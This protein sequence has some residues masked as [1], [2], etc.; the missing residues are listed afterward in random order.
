M[1]IE[2]KR[3]FDTAFEQYALGL[4]GTESEIMAFRRQA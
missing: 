1:T 4:T 3:K 2:D